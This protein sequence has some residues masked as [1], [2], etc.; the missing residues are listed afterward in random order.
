M[1][2]NSKEL[3]R[4][5]QLALEMRENKV[6]VATFNT[7]K[8]DMSKQINTVKYAVQDTFRTLLATDNYL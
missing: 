2:A 5:T 1:Q 6:D 3:V 4:I 8:D 7:V